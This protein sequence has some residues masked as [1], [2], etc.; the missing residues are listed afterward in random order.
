VGDAVE[1]GAPAQNA[2]LTTIDAA[3]ERPLYSINATLD[4]ATGVITAQQ[5][6]DFVNPTGRAVD[7]LRF[8]VPPAR[9]AGAVAL[10]DVRIHGSDSSLQHTLNDAVLT[11]RLPAALPPNAAIAL[12][13]DFTLS[14]PLQEVIT[15]IGGDDTSR[16][17]YS[18]TA[19]HWY[20]MLAPFRDGVWDTPA[21]VPVGDPYTS[22]L[23]DY[24]VAILA[25]ADVVIAGAGDESRSGRLWNYSL[26]KAR[27]F[28]F[29]ASTVYAVE[30]LE[31]NGVTFIHYGYPTHKQH[32]SDVLFTAARAVEL[33]TELY[34][35]YPYRTLR[36]VETG[37]QQGQEY[38]AMVGLGSILY[39]GYPGRGSRHD[40]IATTVHEIAHQWWF[41]VVG[42]DQIRTPWLD[43][44]FAR[45][46][47]LRFYQ[48]YYDADSDWWFSHYITARRPTGP[49]DLSLSEYGDSSKYIA[50]VYQ[51]GLLFLNDV[52]KLLGRE[53][54]DE[55]LRD[56]YRSQEYAITDQDAFFDALARHTADDLR[57]LVR[58]YFA[59]P[60]ALPCAISGGEPGCR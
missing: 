17:P 12:A 39:D 22:E 3:L 56:Y 34:G 26:Q 57:P 50:G 47:E 35:P 41:N 60:V 4:Y 28:A 53:K 1:S 33:F 20:V 43:E 37:R 6:I 30:T 58:G 24:E 11:V 49:I 44:S 10:H 21:Y 52:R 13:F 59:K 36:I 32:G 31:Q 9:R 48:T 54:F 5:R 23:A 7:E 2:A 8:N 27:V 18:L 51:R 16:G 42:N 19:G 55:M 38:S 45:M 15:G 29:A 14:I 25:P 46:A 40:L